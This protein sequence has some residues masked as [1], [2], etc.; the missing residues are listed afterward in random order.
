[1]SEI[2]HPQGN[3]ADSVSAEAGKDKLLELK[4]I[5]KSFGTTDAGRR[6]PYHGKSES[7]FETG[8]D[9]GRI[10]VIG[11]HGEDS[12]Q[13]NGGNIPAKRLSKHQQIPSDTHR[14]ADSLRAATTAA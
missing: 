13:E 10:E 7:R 6:T 2:R 5:S 4:G 1:M 8:R 14:T 11:G 3:P 12:S 9:I